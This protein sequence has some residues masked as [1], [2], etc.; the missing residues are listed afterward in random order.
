[1]NTA[2]FQLQ[3]HNP[4]DFDQMSRE[5]AQAE[6]IRGYTVRSAHR[7]PLDAKSS[8]VVSTYIVEGE[9]MC[10]GIGHD[11]AP[12]T[13]SDG[14]P[15]KRIIEPAGTYFS[16]PRN[17]H[18]PAVQAQRPKSTNESFT[19]K[20]IVP[21][22]ERTSTLVTVHDAAEIINAEDP[23]NIVFLAGSS[24]VRSKKHP[25]ASQGDIL[26]HLKVSERADKDSLQRNRVFAQLFDS[27]PKSAAQKVRGAYERHTSAIL[28]TG[29]PNQAY[30]AFTTLMGILKYDPA[31]I[32]ADFHLGGLHLNPIMPHAGWREEFDYHR[33]GM[34]AERGRLH[35]RRSMQTIT[36]RGVSLVV[37]L[38]MEED[39][40]GLYDSLSQTCPDAQT[41]V[42]NQAAPEALPYTRDTLH[43]Q[44][45]LNEI[46]PLLSA[47]IMTR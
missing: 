34:H 40:M 29:A 44:G 46:M 1:M 2:E 21:G 28:S 7:L 41:L 16:P 3:S 42:I 6:L 30:R 27:N 39:G 8:L 10:A 43:L 5:A 17:W 22:E 19:T 45:H 25:I 13:E 31:Y 23:R 20:R 12:Y 24:M 14:Q 32:S 26:A 38:G 4:D 37:M 35:T 9:V 11:R 33:G 15:A 47:A 36:N 18:T